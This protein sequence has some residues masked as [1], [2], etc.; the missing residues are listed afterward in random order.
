MKRASFLGAV[1]LCIAALLYWYFPGAFLSGFLISLFGVGIFTALF[2]LY[3]TRWLRDLLFALCC[4]LISTLILY[5]P[6]TDYYRTVDTYDGKT[7]TATVQLTEDPKVVSTGSYRYVAKPVDGPF[8]QKIVFFSSVYYTDGG[9]TVTAEFTFSRP[10][11][12]YFLENLSD[13]VALIGVIRNPQE[14]IA[15]E[16]EPSFYTVSSSLRRY[17]YTTFLRYIGGDEGG[18]MNAVLTGNKDTLSSGDYQVLQQTGM[19]HVVAVSGLH[20]SVFISFVLFFLQ[21]MR[22]IRLQIILSVLSL[23][24]ILLFSGFTPSVCRAVIMNLIVFGGT[25]VSVR[26][27]PFNRLGLSAIVILLV[28]PYSVWSLSF[29]LSFC[30]A[31]GI[32]LFSSPVIK[33][34]IQW[35]FVRC[36]VICGSVLRNLISLFSVS[37]SAFILTLPILWMRLDSYSVWSLF[38]SPI[39]LPILQLCFFGALILLL[40]ALISVFS[41]F[42]KILGLLI[43]YGVKFMIY[44]SSFAVSWMDAV[45][46]VPPALQWIFAVVMLILAALIY[47]LPMPKTTSKKK[48]KRMVRRGISLVFAAISLLTIYQAA[49]SVSSRITVGDV[50]P[51]ENVL[52]TA[53][54]DVGQGNCIVTILNQQA[55]VVDCGGTKQPGM[56]ASDYLTSAGINEV[57]FVLISHLH[58]DHANGLEDLCE[59]K[60]IKEIIIPYTEGDASLYAQI[61]VLAE[62]EGATLTVLEDDSQRSL[63]SSN[64]RLLTRHLDATSDDQNENSIV[65]LCEFGNYRGLFTGD[66]TSKAETRLV[67]CYGSGL[68]CDVL[69]V[70]HHGS[71]SSSSKNFLDAVTPVYSVISVGA[72]NSYGHPTQE[73]IDRILGVGSQILRT[74]QL[75]TV[76]IRSDGARM[77]VVDYES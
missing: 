33:A 30:A 18:F 21:K 6:V 5:F 23:G 64:L 34:I 20:V 65:G 25:W 72:K 22:D 58:D 50:A 10:K 16:P 59:E 44:C 24:I 3:K 76:T 15:A 14:V 11:D 2:V 42:C 29:Q 39:L 13:G 19:L 63:G 28:S 36:H 70:P 74:D 4:F 41:P 37:V 73:A 57:E 77:E 53:F 69:L 1:V 54:L 35:L 71:K 40:I 27:E 62:N 9:G 38:L 60:E 46:M 52:Q 12:V 61:V 43:S 8:S 32:L 17:A 31:L 67:S 55:Y 7:V 47:F 26:T 49:E 48:K 68:D 45:E 75:S 66:I 51:S 56:V